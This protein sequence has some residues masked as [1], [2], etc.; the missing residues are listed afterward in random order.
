MAA[1][2]NQAS[3]HLLGGLVPGPMGNAHPNIVPY[4][5]FRGSDRPF[6]LAAGND[7]MFERTCRVIDRPELAADRRF[8][9]NERRVRHRGEL[10]PVLE[11]AFQARTAGEWIGARWLG[12]MRGQ[13]A[14]Q[15]A[16]EVESAR[17][18]LAGGGERQETV[19]VDHVDACVHAV[20]RRRD[21]SR[22]E[23]T[24]IVVGDEEAGMARER[25]DQALSRAGRAFDPR[26]I[27]DRRARERAACACGSATS[28]EASSMRVY[29]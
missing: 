28:V 4:Q 11:R 8:A 2:V 21:G 1:L 19:A 16:T 17:E 22:E 3:N 26:V 20:C 12:E 29:G 6:I 9:T 10:I 25:L 14:L 24:G 15:E 5:L 13:L 18:H 23:E 7:R 27:E